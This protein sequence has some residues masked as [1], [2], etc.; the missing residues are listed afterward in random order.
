MDQKRKIGILYNID[1]NWIGGKYYLDSL[2]SV[3]DKKRYLFDVYIISPKRVFFNFLFIKYSNNTVDKLFTVIC[4]RF[5]DFE[6]S[7]LSKFY[8]KF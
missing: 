6:F 7:T 2:L 3:L 4:H 8:V 5:Y 1:D